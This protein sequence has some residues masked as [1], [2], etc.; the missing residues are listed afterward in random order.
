MSIPSHFAD[1]SLAAPEYPKP[2]IVAISYISLPP[3]R[4]S[5]IFPSRFQTLS[6]VQTAVTH[7][8]NRVRSLFL[9]NSARFY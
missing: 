8:P 7:T 9:H 1:S 4:Y 5:Q 2:R 6:L 3:N